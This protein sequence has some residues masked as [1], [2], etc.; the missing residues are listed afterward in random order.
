MLGPS[1]IGVL[2]VRQEL[3]ERMVPFLV[4]GSTIK[5]AHL[6]G[7]IFDDPP[8]CFE[9]GTPN[10][11]GAIAFGRA[12]DYLAEVGMEAIAAHDRQLM[13][14]ALERLSSLDTVEIY[15]SRDP[16]QRLAVITFNV[17]GVGCHSVA[18]VLCL[19]ENIMIRSGFHCAQP[20]HD[21]LGI[22]PTARVSFYLYNTAEE[23]E[24]MAELLGKLAQ[25]L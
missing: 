2:Y 11:E 7:H 23:V 24:R 3:Y 10:I 8:L 13:G 20:L 14:L 16:A 1:G 18:K 22:G 5:E 6:D 9:A 15:G 19:R 12:I 25:F 17:K 21:R 4:G